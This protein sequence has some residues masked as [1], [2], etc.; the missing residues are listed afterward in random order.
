[1]YKKIIFFDF[2]GTLFHTP[3]PLQGE[4]IWF[5][6]T[7]K[8]WPYKGWWG[9]EES[10]D[11]EVFNIPINDWVYRKY[12][13][14]IADDDACVILATGR[15]DKAVN[16]RNRVESILIKNNLSFDGIYLNTGGDTFRF[17]TKLFETLTEEIGATEMIMYDDRQEHLVKF[18]DWAT[19]QPFDVTV[20]DVINKETKTFQNK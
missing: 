16:M 19:D 7:G 2:D 6:K 15:L 18:E 14:A 13:E 5:D 11:T 9:K 10:L 1:M 20:V 3:E 8:V 4:K 12:L 17:K